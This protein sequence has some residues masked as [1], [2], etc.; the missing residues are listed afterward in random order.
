MVPEFKAGVHAG[1]VV[2][3]EVGTLQRAHV[4]H[5]DV[6]NTAAR[7]Q[8]KCNELGCDLLVSREALSVL[9]LERQ[10]RF[11][12]L[13]PVALRGKAETLVVYALTEV[14]TSPGSS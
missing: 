4:Y 14:R 7:I 3:S 1:A 2:V 11:E 6:L 13:A 12:A 8:S 10:G 9:P 5:G